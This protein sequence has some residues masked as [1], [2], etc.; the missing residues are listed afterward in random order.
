MASKQNRNAATVALVLSAFC[1]GM[2]LL[3]GVQPAHAGQEWK[4]YETEKY[5]FALK[6]PA[7]FELNSEEKGATW[8]HQPGSAETEKTSKKKKKKKFG[9][10][11][12]G[13]GVSTEQSEESSSDASGGGG[14]ESALTIYVNWVWMPDVSSATMYS[15]NKDSDQKNM[16][17]PDPD[18]KDLVTFDKKK[19]YAM[20][21]NT[22][23]YKEVDQDDGGEIHRWHIKSYGNKSAYTIGLC[24]TYAQFEKWGPI[25]EDVIKSWKLIPLKEN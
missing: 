17:S 6:I 12:R 15:T 10:N 13:I 8:L 21:G 24:G 5:G 23:W 7:E 3:L 11:I 16:K 1:L 2:A 19:G 14:L 9:I 18:Y 25:Y 4:T 20:E 22:Y